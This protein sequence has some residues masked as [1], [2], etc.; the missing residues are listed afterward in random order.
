MFNVR[1]SP[2]S[3]SI[4]YCVNL[5]RRTVFFLEP[6]KVAPHLYALQLNHVLDTWRLINSFAY[7][8]IFMRYRTLIVGI[9]SSSLPPGARGDSDEGHGT[10]PARTS[11][12]LISA[13]LEYDRPH[14]QP[15]ISYVWSVSAPCFI[16]QKISGSGANPCSVEPPNALWRQ[17]C[18]VSHLNVSQISW[19]ASVL[20]VS[21]K[22][23]I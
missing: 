10:W 19:H 8:K 6:H 23:S 9:C 3:V 16:Q 17:T 5:L 1:H 4:I 13:Q 14:L 22:R 2:Q 12:V 20:I 18:W 11:E 7:L 15:S 21:T